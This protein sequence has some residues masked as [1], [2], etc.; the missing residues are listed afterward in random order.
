[1]TAWSNDYGYDDYLSRAIPGM[2]RRGD[3]VILISGSGNSRNVIEAYYACRKSRIQCW[4]L[5]GQKG[6]VVKQLL[7]K[8]PSPLIHFLLVPAAAYGPTED[9]HSAIIHILRDLLDPLKHH[10]ST[11]HVPLEHDERWVYDAASN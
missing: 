2:A 11:I 7:H 4:M 10:P 6:G 8:S 3:M 1:M 5:L 9:M